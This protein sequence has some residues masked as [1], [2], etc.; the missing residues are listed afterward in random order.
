M[1]LIQEALEKAARRQQS[2]AVSGPAPVQKTPQVPDISPSLEEVL[3]KSSSSKSFRP[4]PKGRGEFP[5]F[6]MRFPAN[7]A[8]NDIKWMD[9]KMIVPFAVIAACLF[10]FLLIFAFGKKVETSPLMLAGV[11]SLPQTKA[12]HSQPKFSLTGITESTEG[13]LALINNQ[14]AAVG[15]RLK[16]KAF[17]KE[18]HEKSVVLEFNGRE[19]KLTL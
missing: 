6:K 19:I 15:D 12:D 8:R 1:S 3:E 16:E 4:V 17:V 2:G 11:S 10:F 14:V 18:I 5:F 9:R 7:W 13:K